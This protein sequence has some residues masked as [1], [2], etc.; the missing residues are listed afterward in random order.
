MF[1]LTNQQ[2]KITSFNPRAEKHGEENVPAGDIR[3][4]IAHEIHRARST[5]K[6]RKP[7]SK[8]TAKPVA[9]NH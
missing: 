5:P 4:R 3:T 9:S 2:T 8:A 6:P 7:S 1:S